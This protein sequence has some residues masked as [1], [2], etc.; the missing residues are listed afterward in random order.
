MEKGITD[1]ISGNTILVMDDEDDIL[2]LYKINLE[3]LGC[4]ALLAHNGDEAIEL[5]KESMDSTS[6]ISATILDMNINGGEGGKEV[7]NKLRSLDPKVRLIISSGDSDSQ[8][9]IHFEEYGFNAAIVKN[10][11]RDEIRRVL[12]QVLVAS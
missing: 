3:K 11:N 2:D 5:F 12:S 8:E 1:N 9:M 4:K 6:P 7:A 10:F